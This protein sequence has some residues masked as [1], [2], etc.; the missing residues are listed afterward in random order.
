MNKN[1]KSKEKTFFI[2]D[3]N[4]TMKSEEKFV[5]STTAIL[6]SFIINR[7]NFKNPRF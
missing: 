4:A 1:R 5:F 2:R 3:S 6:F 7:F